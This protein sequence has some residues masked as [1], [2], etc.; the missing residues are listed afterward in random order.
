LGVAR[1]SSRRATSLW[2]I[3]AWFSKSGTESGI[4]TGMP[5]ER[6]VSRRAMAKDQDLEAPTMESENLTV[7]IQ[8]L[9][10]LLTMKSSTGMSELNR[11]CVLFFASSA[12]GNYF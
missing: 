9:L 12:V 6:V 5:K 1:G 11:E 3:L 8:L 7:L 2:S 10:Q 4:A